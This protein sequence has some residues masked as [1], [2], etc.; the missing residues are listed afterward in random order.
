MQNSR[1]RNWR[2]LLKPVDGVDKPPFESR[3][4]TDRRCRLTAMQLDGV[5]MRPRH[6]ANQTLGSTVITG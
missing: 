3:A 1:K 4:S 5:T 2:G 6:L